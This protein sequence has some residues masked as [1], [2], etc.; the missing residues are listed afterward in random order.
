MMAQKMQVKAGDGS[1]GLRGKGSLLCPSV[2]V[3]TREKA[4]SF[5]MRVEDE[6]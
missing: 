5:T 2:N 6:S 4:I 3:L 1:Q